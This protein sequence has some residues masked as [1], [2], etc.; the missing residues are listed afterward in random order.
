MSREFEWGF[1]VVKQL[2]LYVKVNGVAQSGLFPSK[3][4]DNLFYNLL[5]PHGD[6][7]SVSRALSLRS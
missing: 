1:Q 4:V 5:S 2:Q 3:C 7:L 6:Y